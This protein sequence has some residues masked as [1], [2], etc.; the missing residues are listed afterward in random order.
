MDGHVRSSGVAWMSASAAS[1]WLGDRDG[2]SSTSWT[3]SSRRAIASRSTAV[4]GHAACSCAGCG[5]DPREISTT[6]GVAE[7]SAL[8]EPERARER[9]NALLELGGRVAGPCPA[10]AKRSRSS[11]SLGL[12]GS[13]ARRR[14]ARVCRRAA[15]LCRSGG[16]ARLRPAASSGDS[17]PAARRAR[18]QTKSRTTA[19]TRDR[20]DRREGLGRVAHRVDREEDEDDRRRRDPEQDDRRRERRSRDRSR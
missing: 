10:R 9:E 20:D 6:V 4:G 13:L 16:A 14:G 18:F 11:A 15:H 17:A 5:S 2:S 19:S 1:A 3:S 7:I 12:G 8:R